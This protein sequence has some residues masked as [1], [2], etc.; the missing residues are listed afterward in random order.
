MLGFLS[1]GLVWLYTTGM[2]YF[3]IRKRD[4]SLHQGMMI[5]SYAACFGAVTL[6]IWL[7]ILNIVFG[8]FLT[9]Y[10]IVAWLAWVPNIVFA[11][12]WVR[13]KGIVLG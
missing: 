3:A 6:R 13:R 7:P 9:A 8:D 4:I 12:F 11:Y 2:A 5:Y 1:L 10:K